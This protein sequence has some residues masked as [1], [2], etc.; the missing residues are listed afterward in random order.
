[1]EK[2]QNVIISFKKILSGLLILMRNQEESLPMSQ[3]EES[4]SEAEV[5]ESA[6]KSFKRAFKIAFE[7]SLFDLSLGGMPLLKK[8]FGKRIAK[9]QLNAILLEIF[10]VMGGRNQFLLQEWTKRPSDKNTT[11][12]KP[13]QFYGA[14]QEALLD[15]GII[16][17]CCWWK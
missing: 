11:G 16:G 8:T 9:H 10:S 2:I 3:D 15:R 17:S 1:V 7:D 12:K 13:R 5:E 4:E 6:S 14:S